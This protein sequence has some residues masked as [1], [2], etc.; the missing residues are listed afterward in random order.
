MTLSP[1]ERNLAGAVEAAL[2]LKSAGRRS[3]K[4]RLWAGVDPC[5]VRIFTIS[6]RLGIRLFFFALETPERFFLLPG[7]ARHLFLALFKCLACHTPYFS[8]YNG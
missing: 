4:L 1:R 8:M 5:E 7:L 2:S 6:P 3:E